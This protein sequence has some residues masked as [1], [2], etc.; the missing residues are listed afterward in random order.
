MDQLPLFVPDK[1]DVERRPPN[2]DYI[3]KNLMRLLRTARNAEVMPW[4]DGEAK[5]WEERF[6]ELTAL[7][8]P[9]EGE[10]ILT[11][12]RAELERLRKAA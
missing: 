12:F 9:E 5:G 4:S 10:A 11:A 3:R 2:L 1:K 6:P 8:G 7:L